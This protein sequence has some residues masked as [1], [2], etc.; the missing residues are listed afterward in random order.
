MAPIKRSIPVLLTLGLGVT[1]AQS[2]KSTPAKTIKNSLGM[3][4]ILIP[5]GSFQMGSGPNVQGAQAN[6][7]P[8][9]QVTLSR[10]FYLG[11]FEVTQAQWETVMGSSAYTQERSN[12]YYD[13]PGMAQRVREPNNPVTVSWNDAQEFIGRLNQKEGAARYRLPS[14]AE[15]EYAARA[16]TTTAYSF[17]N[18]ERQLGQY[19]W[20][21]EDFATGSMH[22]VGTKRPN[23]WG[24]HDMHGNVWEW[25]QDWY[26]DSYGSNRAVTDPKGPSSGTHRVVRGGSGSWHVTGTAG[27]RP[28]GGSTHRITGVSASGFAW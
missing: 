22:P 6:E 17:G 15:W 7:K 13:L 9:H 16:G 20:H 23:P 28:S 26:S 25:V 4:F 11:Q 24:L 14:E 8:Q 19:A 2:S 18:D 12:P 3:N 27:A 1:T 21:G 10:A 5:A